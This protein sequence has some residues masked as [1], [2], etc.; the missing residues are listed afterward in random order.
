MSTDKRYYTVQSGPHMHLVIDR[1]HPTYVVAYC[2][3]DMKAE[4][5]MWLLNGSWDKARKRSE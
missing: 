4:L 3:D 5:I 2:P 1:H